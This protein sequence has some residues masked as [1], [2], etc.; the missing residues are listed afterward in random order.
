M[1]FIFFQIVNKSVVPWVFLDDGPGKEVKPLKGEWMTVKNEDLYVGGL[2]KEW[3]TPL[4]EFVNDH[5][6]WVKIVDRHGKIR[7]V[8]WHENYVKV[9]HFLIV[10]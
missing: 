5:P 3:S 1:T 9:R 4:G 8:N 7:H 6:M 2:G 10:R